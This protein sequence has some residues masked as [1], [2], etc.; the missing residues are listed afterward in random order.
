MRVMDNAPKGTIELF[1]GY[2]YSGIPISVAAGLAVQDILKKMISFNRARNL[3]SK[4]INVLKDIDVVENKGHGMMGGI[5]IR[6]DGNQ[7]WLDLL[8]SSIVMK[9]LYFKATGD[10]LIKFLNH[11]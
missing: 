2:T 9:P 10:C 11:K 5:D 4:R 6:M 7:V 1:H 3:F 8:V